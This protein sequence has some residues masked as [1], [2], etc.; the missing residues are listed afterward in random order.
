M[1]HPCCQRLALTAALLLSMGSGHA[2]AADGD[3]RTP[4]IVNEHSRVAVMEYEAWFGP[5][6]VTFQNSAAR[7][8]LR[9]PDMVALGGGYESADP[10]VIRQ[11]VAW[12]EQLGVDAVIADL[13]NAVSCIFD[14]EWFVQ[15]YLQNFGSCP[16]LRSDYQSI[17]DN[18]GNLYPAWTQLHTRLKI[19]PLL[20]GIDANELFLDEDG[21][22]AFQKEIEYFGALMR[23]YPQ[24]SVIYEGKPLMLVFVGAA[25]DP[26]TAD[27]PLWYQFRQFLVRHPELSDHYTFRQ[28]AG[29]LDSQPDLWRKPAQASGAREIAPQYAFWSWVDRLKPVC[30][31][32][33]CPYYPSY[34]T[35]GARAENLTVSI[36]TAGQSGW[37]CP[38][39]NAKPYCEDAA[40]RFGPERIYDTLY[41]FLPYVRRLDPIFLIVHQFNEFV[42]PDEGFDANTNDDVEPAD[43]WGASAL[44]PVRRAIEFYHSGACSPEVPPAAA[45][46]ACARTD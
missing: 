39:P 16:I 37:G 40:L 13:T 4:L 25:Q 45:A 29:Y 20:G 12:L 23:R 30:S 32:P 28:V 15:K 18:T 8:W 27:H 6:A 22:T 36:A 3:A 14:S 5:N 1:P 46:P 41:S 44:E 9:S 10:K 26:S 38:N 17:R 7:P 2:L 11:H 21:E 42:M 31:D 35:H 24:L 33:S 43:L 34:N 19:I